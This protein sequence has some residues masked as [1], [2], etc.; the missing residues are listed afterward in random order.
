MTTN[1]NATSD[2]KFKQLQ[3]DSERHQKQERHEVL[4]KRIGLLGEKYPE[5]APALKIITEHP[6]VAQAVGDIGNSV[7][8]GGRS[9]GGKE[10]EQNIV[11]CMPEKYKD[12]I[13]LQQ[14]IRIDHATGRILTKKSDKGREDFVAHLK[15]DGELQI[16]DHVD[17]LISAKR[18]LRERYKQDF[19]VAN[20]VGREF[21]VTLGR[22]KNDISLGKI[23][24][25]KNNNI[26]LVI[27]AGVNHPFCTDWE[28]IRN[29]SITLE[30]MWK[31]IYLIL[32][33]Q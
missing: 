28:K 12:I 9:K 20:S 33:K 15:C 4:I 29:Q 27:P 25:M 30:D 2:Q 3:E 24:E 26:T 13:G 31:E 5:C 7:A 22:D 16:N 6:A 8:Q 19:K 17:V 10:L 11:M 23:E 21:L 1:M 18:T 14:Q 32:S